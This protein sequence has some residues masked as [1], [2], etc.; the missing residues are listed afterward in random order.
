MSTATPDPAPP[1][2][3]EL[4]RAHHERLV[5]FF[6]QEAGPLLLRFESAEDLAQGVHT[7]AIRSHAS[8]EVRDDD[9]SAGWLFTIAR[10]YLHNRRDH[11]F[12]LKRNGAGV[13]RL[14]WDG[15]AGDLAGTATGPG[16]FADRRE[17]LVLITRALALLPARDRDL[18][19]WTTDN[20]PLAEQA[21]RLGIAYDATEKART[22]A[23]DRL[24]KAYVVVS[25]GREG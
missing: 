6:A 16:T 7:E 1:A 10:R 5:G 20:V 24:R 18:V 9:S 13:L 4:L 8:M 3:A 14:T 23:L 21:D 22:R 17:Q 11:W 19:R 2:I 15:G 25:R 12:A